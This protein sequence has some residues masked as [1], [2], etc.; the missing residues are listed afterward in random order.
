MLFTVLLTAGYRRRLGKH[1]VHQAS[2]HPESRPAL[3]TSCWQLRAQASSQRTN[4]R[5]R[6][7]RSPEPQVRRIGW[8]ICR[9]SPGVSASWRGRLLRLDRLEKVHV[10]LGSALMPPCML[11]CVRGVLSSDVRCSVL[12]LCEGIATSAKMPASILRPCSLLL[13]LFQGPCQL[14][15]EV[16]STFSDVPAPLLDGLV[17]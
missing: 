5:S 4:V 3:Q 7:N 15:H 13:L 12:N 16:Q 11:H 8:R 6:P 1:Y 10:V 2:P 17:N 9:V 14:P